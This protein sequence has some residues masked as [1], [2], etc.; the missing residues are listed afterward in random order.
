MGLPVSRQ[1]F[2]SFLSSSILQ[3]HPESHQTFLFL[4]TSNGGL[5]AFDFVTIT[6]GRFTPNTPPRLHLDMQTFALS[7]AARGTTL[8]TR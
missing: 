8:I 4:D 6:C 2:G 5:I 7:H 3:Q 1:H